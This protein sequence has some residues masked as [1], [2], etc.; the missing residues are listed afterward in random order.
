M[1][2]ALPPARLLAVLLTL[3]MAATLALVPAEPAS[4]WEYTKRRNNPGKVTIRPV[5]VFDYYTQY[6]PVLTLKARGPRARRK[7]GVRGAQDVNVLYT[8]Q[9]WNGSRWQTVT[10]QQRWRTIPRG[11]KAVRLP[12][13]QVQPNSAV[14]YYRVRMRFTWFRSGTQNLIALARVRPDRRSD[15]SC[16]TD[17]RLCE[18]GRGWVRIGRHAT[19]GGGW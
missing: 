15:F 13:M 2:A 9:R 6:G 8:V 17:K 19:V 10:S 7:P 4:A 12:R 11:R 1:T 14:G 16:A 3:V 5:E 18:A